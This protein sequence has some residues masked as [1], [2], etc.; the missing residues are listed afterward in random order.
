MA[1]ASLTLS[2]TVPIVFSGSNGSDFGLLSLQL[3][4]FV[5]R[6]SY[7]P[8]GRWMHGLVPSASVWEHTAINATVII[9]GSTQ[10]NLATNRAA[11]KAALGRMSYTATVMENSVSQAFSADWGS[12]A[13][14]GDLDLLNLQRLYEVY[15]LTIPVHPT[16]VPS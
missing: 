10:S 5:P 16:V 12:M 1:T 2:G 3:P 9:Q 6:T 14:G 8:A 11:V 13:L 7:A 4:V 15:R